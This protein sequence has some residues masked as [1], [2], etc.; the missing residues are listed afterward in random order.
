MVQGKPKVL[1]VEDVES[2][3]II[4]TA[5]LSPVAEVIL[6]PSFHAALKMLRAHQDIS[7]V[8]LDGR[9]P[10]FTGEPLRSGDTTH[11]LAY[12]ILHSHPG[13]LI[14]TASADEVLNK[15]L[16][17]IGGIKA[18]KATAARLICEAIQKKV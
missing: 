11:D 3:Q 9:V 12:R 4:A 14:Y 18:N 16:A 8:V 7:Y 2:E 15:E 10:C 6:A 1:L 13:A 17:A 5:I